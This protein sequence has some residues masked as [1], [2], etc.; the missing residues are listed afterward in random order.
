M[1]LAIG[2]K[3]TLMLMAIFPFM[4][5]FG[6]MLGVF[7]GA[8][9]QD[10]MKAYAQSAGYAE[11]ALQ[12]IKVV[13]TYGREKLEIK[14][15]VKNLGSV[16]D[17]Q[18]S[19]AKKIAIVVAFLFFIINGTYAYAFFLG[20][21]LKANG[22]TN[23]GVEYTGGTFLSCIWCVLFGSMGLSFSA[24]LLKVF[25]EGQIAGHLA[26]KVIDHIPNII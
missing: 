10:E 5:I 19:F 11:Q 20:S 24:P 8:H 23:R 7:F 15:Y 18:L 2:W 3:F 4:M 17:F 21:T 26:F 25:K 14:N 16:R 13:Q 1:A 6:A 12:S 9:V 22:T